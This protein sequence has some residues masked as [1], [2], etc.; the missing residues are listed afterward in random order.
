V[1]EE[2]FDPIPAFIPALERMLG[3]ALI[4]R[5][6]DPGPPAVISATG[7]VDNEVTTLEGH[8]PTEADAWRD[9]ALRLA[10]WRNVDPRQVRTYLG[11]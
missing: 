11:I 4:V 5:D 7:M 10:A 1:T 6:I 3:V 9:L 8:G 2:A